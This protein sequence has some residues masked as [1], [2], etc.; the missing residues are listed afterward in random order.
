MEQEFQSPPKSTRRRPSRTR[1]GR[2]RRGGR[3][4]RVLESERPVGL[5]ELASVPA[6][7]RARPHAWSVRSSAAGL[8]EQDGQRGRLRPGPAISAWPSAACCS[9][10]TSSSSPG[11][12]SR[13]SPAPGG[14]WPPLPAPMGVEHVAQLDSQHFLGVGQ[15]LGRSVD[16]H[17]TAN[18]KVFLAFDRAPLP[19]EPVPGHTPAHDRLHQQLHESPRVRRGY[20][21]AVDPRAVRGARGTYAIRGAQHLRTDAA[22]DARTNRR[23]AI[24][25]EAAALSRRL[26]HTEQRTPHD[27][28]RAAA[29]AL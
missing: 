25:H 13:R 8:I 17:S 10:A 26:G 5:T 21:A 11:R 18:G 24:G 12:I 27:A 15:W 29:D 7:P 6:S 22:H 20:A 4:C 9:S 19:E 2:G 23:A 14:R 1:H 28:S 3:C 16:F